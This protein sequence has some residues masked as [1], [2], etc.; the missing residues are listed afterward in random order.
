MNMHQFLS[1]TRKVL[2]V[3][4]VMAVLLTGTTAA[5]AQIRLAAVTA[6]AAKAVKSIKSIAIGGTVPFGADSVVFTNQSVEIGSTLSPN[7][8]PALPAVLIIDLNF[9]KVGGIAAA[10]N[11]KY[12]SEFQ[13]TKVRPFSSNVVLEITFPFVQTKATALTSAESTQFLSEA[14]T[15]LATFNLTFDTNGVVTGASGKIGA[16]TF[17]P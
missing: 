6:P 16:N 10:S 11:V 2:V 15:G 13:V 3:I 14:P 5:M 1:R 17:A 4:P 12:T 9:I 7:S 8:D